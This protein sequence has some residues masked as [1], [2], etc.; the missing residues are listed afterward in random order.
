MKLSEV[1]EKT[2]VSWG[3]DRD[4]IVSWRYDDE[5]RLIVK[6]DKG[7]EHEIW[8]KYGRVW[9]KGGEY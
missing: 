1:I 2:G 6:T 7:T 4:D 9:E 3:Y 5:D 8:L